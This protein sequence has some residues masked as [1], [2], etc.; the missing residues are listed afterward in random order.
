MYEQ[1]EQLIRLQALDREVQRLTQQLTGIAPQIEETRLHLAAAERALEEGKSGVEGARKDRRAA[2]KDLEEQ[3]EKRR[4]F[5]EQQSKVKTNKEYQALMGELASLKLQETAAEDR[6]LA[7]MEKQAE[8]EKLL[9]AL[10][11]EV[12]RE[13]L[14]F[15]QRERVLRET[16]QQLRQELAAAEAGRAGI[17]ATLE[18][19]TIVTYQRVLKLR[20]SAVAEVRDEF[21]LG[22][23]TKV[24]PQNFMEVMRNDRIHHCPHCQRILYYVKPEIRAAEPVEPESAA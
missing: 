17:I 15:Q 11:A 6:I 19:P 22:C 4:K 3:I 2:E 5:Q 7:Q 8:T 20:G 10:T 24:T 21:C 9:P 12:G 1:L 14:E 13:K 23:S 18:P 16:E